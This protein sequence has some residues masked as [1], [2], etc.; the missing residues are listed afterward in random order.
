MLK[1]ELDGLKDLDFDLDLVGFSDDELAK[2]LQEPEK[3][4]L[5]DEDEVPEA[6]E[7]PV[8]VEGD[9]WVFRS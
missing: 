9:I 6:P 7:K 4:G 2:L 1:I 3:E 5:T 8:T